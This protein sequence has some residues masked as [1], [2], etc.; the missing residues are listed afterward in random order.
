[1]G[2]L[3]G[4][5]AIITGGGSGIGLEIAKKF[6][7]EGASVVISGRTE[8]KLE[9]AKK[10]LGY[11]DDQLLF[12]CA[13]NCKE[14]DVSE[15][16]RFTVEKRDRI[17]V[18]INNAGSMRNNKPLE[19][20]SLEEWEA[21][22]NTNVN[23]TFMCSREAGKVMIE[24]NYGRI[25]NISSISGF[26]TNRYFHA[27][28]YEVSKSAFTMLTKV[29]AIEWAKYNIVVNAIAPGYYGTQ[30]NI[31]FF[32]NNRDLNDKVLDMIPMGKLGDLK[33]LGSLATYLSSDQIGYMT[34]QTII[35]DGGYTIW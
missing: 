32:I 1:M 30:P 6:I 17:D 5:S 21:V 28:S 20:T 11:S 18:L 29:F 2:A 12:F 22:F 10:G 4:K 33:E 13:D 3:E 25:V 31:D 24:Q 27:G 14:Q 15:L 7:S 9:K 35:I 26:I 34:G 23:G 16:M 8:S 19:K